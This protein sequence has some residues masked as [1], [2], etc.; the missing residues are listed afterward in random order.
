MVRYKSAN[1]NAH[2]KHHLYN[3]IFL[4][5]KSCITSSLKSML[6]AMSDS[7]ALIEE[8]IV[9]LVPH[10]HIRMKFILYPSLN[11]K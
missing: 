6:L 7:I 3:R 10:S 5:L 9:F 11:R 4:R 1:R 2:R 8:L